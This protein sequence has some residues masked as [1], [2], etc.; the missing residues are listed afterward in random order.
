MTYCSG[1]NR[2]GGPAGLDAA[3][4]LLVSTSRCGAPAPKRD[5]KQ[6]EG[7][8]KELEATLTKAQA[9][10]IHIEEANL[11]TFQVSIREHR[12]ELAEVERELRETKPPAEADLNQTVLMVLDNLWQLAYC[13][14]ALVRPDYDWDYHGSLEAR[15]PDPALAGDFGEVRLRN[16][17]AIAVT[18]VGDGGAGGD[19]VAADAEVAVAERGVP[20]SVVQGTGGLVGAVERSV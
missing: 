7:R 14:R 5:R 9:K 6:L 2:G 20:V 4:G 16:L 12:E 10:L 11:A 15:A 3:T 18:V 8:R 1:R 13:C 17:G 19:R